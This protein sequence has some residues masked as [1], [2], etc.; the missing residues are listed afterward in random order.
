M[1]QL[2]QKLID[3]NLHGISSAD[4]VK[5][6]YLNLTGAQPS[7]EVVAQFTAQIGAGKTYATQGD[8]LA[9]AANLSLNTAHLEFM[10]VVQQLDPTFFPHAAI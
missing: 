3:A 5:Q 9:F 10:G 1:G 6:V 2:G 4:L 7:A 8:A